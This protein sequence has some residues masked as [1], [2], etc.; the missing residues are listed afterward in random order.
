MK[1]T[2]QKIVITIL[3]ILILILSVFIII[4]A[5]NRNQQTKQS[6]GEV[7][8]IKNK[9]TQIAGPAHSQCESV[10]WIPPFLEDGMITENYEYYDTIGEVYLSDTIYSLNRDLVSYIHS[11]DNLKESNYY[12]YYGGNY[13]LHRVESKSEEQMYPA[14]MLAKDSIDNARSEYP[15]NPDNASESL[16]R[17]FDR[18]DIELIGKV[19]KNGQQQYE[20]R[21]ENYDNCYTQGA[22]NINKI[23]YRNLLDANELYLT[24]SK[25]YLNSESE[26]NLIGTEI[27]EYTKSFEHINLEEFNRLFTYNLNVPTKKIPQAASSYYD[28]SESEKASMAADFLE[29][30]LPNI[31]LPYFENSIFKSFGSQAFEYYTSEQINEW[32]RLQRSR[33]IFPAGQLGEEM[34]KSL[35]RSNAELFMQTDPNYIPEIAS[36]SYIL[37]ISNQTV[38]AYIGM[39][40]KNMA[41]L[42]QL[43]NYQKTDEIVLTEEPVKLMLN[44]NLKDA[45]LTTTEISGAKYKSLYFENEQSIYKI[46][47]PLLEEYFKNNEYLIINTKNT[48]TNAD[49][50]REDLLK[51]FTYVPQGESIL[52]FQ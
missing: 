11:S 34:Y 16:K 4:D 44:D 43:I 32:T 24:E 29:K 45:I 27:I 38:D 42:Q 23:I 31:E 15:F 5:Q 41:T 47:F 35:L 51:G 19:E 46:N 6:D 2:N 20:I 9:Q 1:F 39:Y 21:Y 25:I 30:K 49:E 3:T 17:H 14:T 50:I 33:E 48:T 13:A 36:L 7:L 26:A 37:N 22:E 10:F 28:L 52:L 12:E 8:F 18:D 40:D